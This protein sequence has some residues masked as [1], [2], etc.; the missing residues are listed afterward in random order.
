MTQPTKDQIR[1]AAPDMAAFADDMRSVFPGSKVTYLRIDALNLEMGIPIDM[2]RC[3]EMTDS[4]P[5][6]VLKKKWAEQYKQ[7]MEAHERRM[8]K[9]KS[10]AVGGRKK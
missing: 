5:I 3:A 4:T 7:Q 6:H 1:A 8:N 2:D 9:P 10:R